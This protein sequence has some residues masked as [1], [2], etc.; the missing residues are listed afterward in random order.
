MPYFYLEEERLL[1]GGE[2]NLTDQD[3]NHAYRVLRLKPGDQAAVSDGRGTAKQGVITASQP[4]NVRVYLQYDL[5]AAESP[6]ELTLVQSLAKGEK[7]E[8]VIRQTV[9][10]GVKKIIPLASGRSI[11]RFNHRKEEKKIY[12]WHS[13]IRSAAAQ[14]RR[15]FLPILEPVHDLESIL[16]LIA[17]SKTLVPFEKEA[18]TSLP[19]V[20]KKPCPEDN[21]VLLLIGPEGGFNSKEVKTIV[22]AGGITVHLGPRILR[23]ETAAVAA[24]AMLQAAWGDF[25]A[26]G[27]H[28]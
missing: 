2:V 18:D 4:G 24:V 7:M 11:P 19:E 5:P 25:S 8:Q 17:G 15:A 16:P 20:L 22:S 6:L 26:K 27:A 13:I 3:T 12:R 9:E 21:A 14:C 10:L 1:T 23:T 28:H